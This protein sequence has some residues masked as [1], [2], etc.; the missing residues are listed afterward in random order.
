MIADN[1]ARAVGIGQQDQAPCLR[2][3]AEIGGLFPVSEHGEAARLDDGGVHRLQQRVLIVAALHHDDLADA[4]LHRAPASSMR[5]S[6]SSPS[7]SIL[8][9][10]FMRRSSVWLRFT[11]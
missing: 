11:A 10:L 3:T 9:W 8:R 1:E 2:Q 5:N 4:G 6:F 7:L